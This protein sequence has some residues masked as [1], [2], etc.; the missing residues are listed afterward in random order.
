MTNPEKL[1]AI[2]R[3]MLDDAARKI[4]PL[5]LGRFRR[6]LIE[7]NRGLAWRV[8]WYL[9]NALLFQGAILGLIPSSMKAMILRAFGAKVGS[10]FVCK[11]RVTIKYP[12]FLEIGDNVWLGEMVWIDDLCR[13]T[14]GSN[15][16]ISQ[17]TYIF[18]GNHDWTDPTFPFF[19]EPVVIGDG[20]W[21][22]AF[23]RIGPGRRIEPHTLVAD[24][25]ASDTS[26]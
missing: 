24:N 18:T 14:I 2:E 15:V 25:G 1:H 9:V 23:Q 7:G 22:T 11:P 17:G 5:D 6:P 20:V 13:V 26:T 10:G 8:A 16:C 4:A 19:C 21:V 12:W 3:K